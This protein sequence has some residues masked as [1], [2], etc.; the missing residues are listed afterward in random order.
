MTSIKPKPKPIKANLTKPGH[1]N[2]KRG[3]LAKHSLS[4]GKVKTASTHANNNANA[5]SDS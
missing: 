4:G 5:R 3:P 1:R 2:W